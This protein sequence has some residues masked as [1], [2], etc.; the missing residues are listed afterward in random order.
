MRM[1]ILPL[2]TRWE[3]P[4]FISAVR[5]SGAPNAE[6]GE[7]CNQLR[8]V[9]HQRPVLVL[10]LL[11]PTAIFSGAKHAAS[12]HGETTALEGDVSLWHP[13]KASTEPSAAGP[14]PR[15]EG[16]H[17]SQCELTLTQ[18]KLS[19][20]FTVV[21]LFWFAR[22]GK[23]KMMW[24]GRHWNVCTASCGDKPFLWVKELGS[25]VKLVF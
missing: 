2:Q 17:S 25:K 18:N 10:F 7:S 8:P 14:G 21:L 6:F 3:G 4:L 15:S 19:Q 1:T 24:Q 13:V 12:V 11:P 5:D 9:P 22:E 23:M 20:N 16:K